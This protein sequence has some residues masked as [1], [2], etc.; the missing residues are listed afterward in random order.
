M[1]CEE[2]VCMSAHLC[3]LLS[4]FIKHCWMDL[5]LLTHQQ[6]HTMFNSDSLDCQ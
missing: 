1:C 4:S 3:V 6:I 2:I 5:D